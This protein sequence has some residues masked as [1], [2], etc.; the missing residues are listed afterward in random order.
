MTG[1]LINLDISKVKLTQGGNNNVFPRNEI[2][3]L[4]IEKYHCSMID[5]NIHIYHNGTYTKKEKVI[6]K[7]LYDNHENITRNQIADVFDYIETKAPELSEANYNYIP[8]KNGYV[9]IRDFKFYEHNPNVIFTSTLN[10]EYNPNTESGVMEDM[11]NKV[12]NYDEET[13]QLLLEI[14]AY[15]LL[16]TNKLGKMF[17][18]AG[19]PGCGKSTVL[20]VIQELVGSNNTSN[21]DLKNLQ[22]SFSVATLH[23]KFLNV[24]DDIDTSTIKESGNLKKL[25]TGEPVQCS[26]KNENEFSFR[27]YATLIF[28]ANDIPRFIDTGGIFDRLVIV[29]FTNRIRGTQNDDKFINEKLHT[30]ESLSHLVNMALPVLKSLMESAK[31]TIP[32]AVKERTDDFQ[33]SN[34][35]VAQW[36]IEHATPISTRDGSY[37]SFVEWCKRNGHKFGITSGAFVQKLKKQGFV[38]ARIQEKSKKMPYLLKI[39]GE[40]IPI[41][42]ENK[43]SIYP[44]VFVPG[45]DELQ[46]PD[47]DYTAKAY[48]KQEELQ[49]LYD[50]GQLDFSKRY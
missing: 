14:V 18:F 41:S 26:L 48:E 9:D 49:K 47:E 40:G 1:E 34:D 19:E 11:L 23:Q 10:I 46:R 25:A 3:N 15:S 8:F 32:Q 44:S 45:G 43:Q 36:I 7:W 50:N 42:E 2:G 28:G 31:F 24:G 16:R 27:N 39:E 35:P 33:E 22:Y 6:K 13:K 20:D 30:Q 38:L 21:V 29:P 5:D 4:L 37:Q 12:S 17:I